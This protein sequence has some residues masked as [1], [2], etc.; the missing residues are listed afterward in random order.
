VFI[1]LLGRPRVEFVIEVGIL[2]V[3]FL[4]VD[5][6]NRSYR[7]LSARGNRARPAGTSTTISLVHLLDLPHVH[8][9]AKDVVIALIPTREGGDFGARKL[10]KR[11]EVQPVNGPAD[12]T[13]EPCGKRDEEWIGKEE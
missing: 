2:D 11:V 10:G 6:D 13:D 12:E 1:E 3:Q 4:R 5:A 8:A 9:A 7:P